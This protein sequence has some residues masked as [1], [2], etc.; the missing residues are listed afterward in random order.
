MTYEKSH[1]LYLNL[2]DGDLNSFMPAWAA[3]RGLVASSGATAPEGTFLSPHFVRLLKEQASIK[4]EKELVL[5]RLRANRYPESVSRLSC[6]YAWTDR[7]TANHVIDFWDAQGRH[8]HPDFLVEVGFNAKRPPTIADSR[9]IDKYIIN[10]ETPLA[11]LGHDWMESYWSGAVYPWNG[12]AEL[13][14]EPLWECLIDGVGA[15]WGS[16]N[17][18]MSGYRLVQTLAPKAL[19]VLELGRIGADLCVRFARQDLWR[20]GQVAPRLHL[21]N[22][23]PHI[24]YTLNHEKSLM[25]GIFECLDENLIEPAAVNGTALLQLDT[26]Q[27]LPD[28]RQ[29]SFDLNWLKSDKTLS[30]LVRDAISTSNSVELPAPCRQQLGS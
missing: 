19:G 3:Y 21:K 11:E 2:A 18:R 23:E 9:W 24:S 26:G 30:S 5:E 16:D 6:I 13:P 28:L 14:Q 1:F 22:D 27:T 15:V 17:L 12:E 4:L 7:A 8:F 29:L 25:D 10:S 20:F